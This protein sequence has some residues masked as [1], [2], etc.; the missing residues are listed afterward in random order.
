LAQPGTEGHVRRRQRGGDSAPQSPAG[1]GVLGLALESYGEGAAACTL[2]AGG[3]GLDPHADIGR[4]LDGTWFEMDGPLAY[5]ISSRHMPAFFGRLLKSAGVTVQDIDLVIP[6]QAS[7]H[8]LH[9]MRRRLGIPAAKLV[10]PTGDARQQV[11]ASIPACS[12]MPCP[13][14]WHA[15]AISFC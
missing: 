7:A 4:F 3:T 8:A 10:D 15:P 12:I 14:D 9:L 13:T 2:R 5:R 1:Q 11:S 6:H